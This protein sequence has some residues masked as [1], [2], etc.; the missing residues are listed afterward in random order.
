MIEFTLSR[1][2]MM[3]C[4]IILLATVIVPVSGAY[5]SMEHDNTVE[6]A[7][8][9]AEAI[10]SFW[11]SEADTMFLRGCDILPSPSYG[12]VIDG[13][14]VTL[15][16]GDDSYVSLIQHEA[17]YF[18]IGYEDNISVERSNNILIMEYQ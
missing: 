18:T 7:D 11:D 4:G 16:N 13:H 6:A 9:I 14:Y 1:V 10:D 5:E 15:T 3:V 2:S 17:K 8:A 12:L